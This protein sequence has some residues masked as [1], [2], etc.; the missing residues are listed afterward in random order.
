MTG[1]LRALGGAEEKKQE[2]KCFVVLRGNMIYNVCLMF[3]AH[4]GTGVNVI[5][6]FE[7]H[8]QETCRIGDWTSKEII[9]YSTGKCRFH[10]H[11]FKKTAILHLF[12]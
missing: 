10:L 12:Y 6:N 2:T 4:Q 3:T 1:S 7:G 11:F 5:D 9:M 8:Q